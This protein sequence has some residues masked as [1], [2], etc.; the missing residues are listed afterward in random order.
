MAKTVLRTNVKARVGFLFHANVFLSLTICFPCR[1]SCLTIICLPWHLPG[2]FRSSLASCSCKFSM[3]F[4]CA[5]EV[6][7]TNGLA[8]MRNAL[9]CMVTA[10]ILGCFFWTCD[11]AT[12]PC[13]VRFADHEALLMVRSPLCI[14]CTGMPMLS[15][16]WISHCVVQIGDGTGPAL[17]ASMLAW[18][19]PTNNV[20]GAD[21]AGCAPMLTSWHCS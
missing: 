1:I 6:F 17:N 9:S 3:A 10:F 12:W 19:S 18:T 16:V 2:F 4:S 13:S 8:D 20:N 14:S 11:I 5:S 7:C 15:K 21:T